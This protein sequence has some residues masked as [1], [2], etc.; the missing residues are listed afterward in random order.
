MQRSE[1][2]RSAG[3]ISN[4]TRTASALAERSDTPMATRRNDS[5]G[6][7]HQRLALPTGAD[8]LWFPERPFVGGARLFPDPRQAEAPNRAFP[9]RQG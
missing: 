5:L 9:G 3:T 6:C 4:D 7:L 8:P 1:A 2:V